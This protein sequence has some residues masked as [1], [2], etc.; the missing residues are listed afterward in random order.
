MNKKN[1][2][3]GI[4]LLQTG[5]VIKKD[6]K[7]LD[8]IIEREYKK[9]SIKTED[10]QDF[11]L[12]KITGITKYDS[13]QFILPDINT[14]GNIDDIN[15]ETL[16]DIYLFGYSNNNNTLFVKKNTSS[17]SILI[18][19]QLN[20]IGRN[21]NLLFKRNSNEKL[22]IN[23]NIILIYNKKNNFLIIIFDMNMETKHYKKFEA[24][25]FPA[26]FVSD[27]KLKEKINKSYLKILINYTYKKISHLRN[28]EIN[29]DY[30]KTQFNDKHLKEQVLVSDDDTKKKERKD[31]QSDIEKIK[32]EINKFEKNGD[33]DKIDNLKDLIDELKINFINH[34]EGVRGLGP[35]ERTTLKAF[36]KW[37]NGGYKKNIKRK[38]LYTLSLAELKQL[39][40]SNGIKMNNN[41]NKIGLIKNYIKNNVNN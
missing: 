11:I 31:I 23:I 39:H 9:G 2:K 26:F 41:R 22:N 6:N 17:K 28:Q 5:I 1:F 24:L 30:I 34:V 29:F 32:E 25:F 40:R 37:I 35:N 16:K 21:L 27:E 19:D 20:H 36:D 18:Q 10:K 12:Y 3:G 33:G 4:R 8:G 13:E 15:K 7:I 14:T 38:E